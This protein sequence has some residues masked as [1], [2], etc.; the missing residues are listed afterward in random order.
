[1][2]AVKGHFSKALDEDDPLEWKAASDGSLTLSL[3]AVSV[4]FINI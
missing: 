2:W 1:M 3:L 4:V